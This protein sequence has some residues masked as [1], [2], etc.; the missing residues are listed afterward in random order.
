MYLSLVD[1]DFNPE[2]PANWVVSVETTCLNRNL[3]ARLPYGGG[4][5]RLSLVDRPAAVTSLACVTPLTPTLRVPQGDRARWRLISHLALN[6]LSLVGGQDAAEAL[7]E[8][9]RLYDFRDSAETRAVI[10]SIRAVTAQR[11]TARAPWDSMGALC[12]GIDVTMDFDDEKIA[13][14]GVFLLASVLE[15]F[16]GLYGSINGFTRLSAKVAG[17]QGVLRKWPPRASERLIL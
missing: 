7:K 4:H 8:I 16:I 12:R 9:L 2:A 6:H 5:P 11:A 1:L 10:D 14:G 13:S 15:R 17:R 3:P